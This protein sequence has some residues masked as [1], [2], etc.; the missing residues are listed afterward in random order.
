MNQSFSDDYYR[1]QFTFLWRGSPGEWN[2]DEFHQDCDGHADILT[3][4]QGMN[5]QVSFSHSKIGSIIC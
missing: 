1:K 3:I 2:P 4:L 5:G